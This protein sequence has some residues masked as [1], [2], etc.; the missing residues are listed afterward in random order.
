MNLLEKAK[1]SLAEA[2]VRFDE[3]LDALENAP[4]DLTEEDHAELTTELDEAEAEMK[5]AQTSVDKYERIYNAR[6]E[7]P[8]VI[9]EEQEEVRAT[10]KVIEERDRVYRKDRPHSF[11]RDM[12]FAK[13]DPEAA[14]RLARHAD[15]TRELTEQRD[16]TSQGGGSGFIPPIYLADEWANVARPG[17]PFADKMPRFPM[18]PQGETVTIPKVSSGA[19]VDVQNPENAAVSETDVTTTTVTANL[20]TIAGQQDLSRQSL[21]RSFPG[22]DMVIFDDLQRA[23]D[24]KLDSQLLNGSGANL[25]HLGIRNVSGPNTSAYNSASPAGSAL[26]PKLYDAIQQIASNRFMQPDMIVMHPRRAAWLASQNYS[27]AAPILQQ[28][29]L[30]QASGLQDQGFAG[31]IAGMPVLLDANVHTNLG[32]TTN[33]DEIYV[34]YSQDIRFAEDNLRQAT[35]EEVLSGNLT[36]RLQLYAYSFFVPHRQV[37]SISIISGTGLVAPTF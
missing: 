4:E 2:E 28:G 29:A 9:T 32:A 8:E 24:A 6:R 27:N 25:Q 20:V 17:R 21:E 23:Y 33:A 7:A 37:K 35:F 26:V 18:P 1:R 16:I 5:S 13:S 10:P 14:K 30:F 31:S 34:L 15:E 36:V 19:T 11:F 3:A 12:V 22:L